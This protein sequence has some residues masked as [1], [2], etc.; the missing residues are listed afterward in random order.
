MLL[1]FVCVK[2]RYLILMWECE[3]WKPLEGDLMAPIVQECYITRDDLPAFWIRSKKKNCDNRD[4]SITNVFRNSLQLKENQN[5]F[6]ENPH[7][8]IHPRMRRHFDL[9][10]SKSVHWCQHW[11]NVFIS[12]HKNIQCDICNIIVSVQ[13]WE[14][15]KMNKY[16]KLYF[17]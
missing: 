1:F 2:A 14:S 5:I 11:E 6:D 9:K 3:V 7:S 4:S 17:F 8:A 10:I 15:S 13:N 16:M 12:D